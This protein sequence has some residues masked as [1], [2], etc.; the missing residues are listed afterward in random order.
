MSSTKAGRLSGEGLARFGDVAAGHLG[1]AK[2]PGLVA[3]V[4]RDDQVHVEALGS[5]S[6]GGPPVRRDSLF[7][8]ASTTKPVTA[9]ATLA[10][11]PTQEQLPT[12]G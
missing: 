9:S 12:F 5:L 10:L 6:V 7:R 3:L 8:I 2:V 4:A 1:D 11:G